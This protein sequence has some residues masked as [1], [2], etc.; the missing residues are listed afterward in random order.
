MTNTCVYTLHLTPSSSF[1]VALAVII[2]TETDVPDPANGTHS[3]TSIYI[4]KQTIWI[5]RAG[6][7]A[8]WVPEQPMELDIFGERLYVAPCTIQGIQL[9]ATLQE[10]ADSVS[11][12]RSTLNLESSDG[13]LEALHKIL[14]GVL[15]TDVATEQASSCLTSLSSQ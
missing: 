7:W 9:V 14:K 8:I 15:E 3:E 10:H 13:I 2:D 1:P 4:G 12:T 5:C 11:S 6:S